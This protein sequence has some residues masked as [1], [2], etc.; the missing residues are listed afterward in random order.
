[1]GQLDFLSRLAI[2]VGASALAYVNPIIT[3]VVAGLI[4][5]FANP[6]FNIVDYRL[7]EAAFEVAA[8][9]GIRLRH[10]PYGEILEVRWVHDLSAGRS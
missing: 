2:A 5:L 4:L 7:T 3:V 10:V 6:L 1:M 9:G 8:F